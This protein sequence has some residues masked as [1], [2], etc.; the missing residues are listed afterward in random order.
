MCR[1]SRVAGFAFAC[2]VTLAGCSK[3]RFQTTPQDAAQG[4]ASGA[5]LCNGNYV[6]NIYRL[7]KLFFVVDSSGSNLYPTRNPG[8]TVC[9]LGEPG[10]VP[11]T[12]P[13]KDFRGGAI[14]DFLGRYRHKTNFHWGLASF[15]GTS[16]RAYLNSGDSM[17]PIFT[18]SPN[19]MYYGL[20]RLFS[21]RDAGATPYRAAFEIASRAIQADPDRTSAAKPNYFVILLTDGFPTDYL[22]GKGGFRAGDLKNDVAGLLAIAPG[23]VNVST[24]FYGQVN[25]PSAIKLLQEIAQMGGGQFASVNDPNSGF[26]IDDVI[27]RTTTS[28]Q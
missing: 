28:C 26:R 19:Q 27:P 6:E 20:D 15:S 2:L 14:S 1:V 9:R 22:D 4:T 11:A 8:G 7:T 24:I 23:Q 3:A 10:C 5:P 18:P 17:S 12:D 25:D 21:Q 16:A 13:S